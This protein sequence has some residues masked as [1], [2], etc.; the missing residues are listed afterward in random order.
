[1]KTVTLNNPADGLKAV[2]NDLEVLLQLDSLH[3][4]QQLFDRQLTETTHN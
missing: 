4:A 2:L 1:M 3:Y